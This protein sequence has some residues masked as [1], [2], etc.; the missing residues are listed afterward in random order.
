LCIGET[1]AATAD[2][3]RAL[4]PRSLSAAADPGSPHGI[5]VERDSPAS[6]A[7]A[8]LNSYDAI[9]LANVGAPSAREERLLDRYVASGG[10]VAIFLG[11]RSQ[12]VAYNRFLNLQGESRASSGS[13]DSSPAVQIVNQPAS[14]DFHLD[15]LGYRHPI[16]AP[17][18]G[19]NRAGLLSVR[20]ARYY[21][22]RL[23]GEQI[24]GAPSVTQVLAYSSG[25]PAI[26]L[27]ERGLG[28]IAVVTTDPAIGAGSQPWSTLAVSPSFVPLVRRLFEGLAI[29]RR[30]GD[31]NRLVG[32]PLSP[33][34][35]AS[36]LSL[37]KLSWK[38]PAGHT[39]SAS[40]AALRSGVYTLEH[41][42]APAISIAVNVDAQESDL[43]SLDAGDVI[44][45]DRSRASLS[46]SSAVGFASATPLHP[47]ALALALALV[48][49]ELAVA[50]LFGR[51]WA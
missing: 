49:V 47:Y 12:P 39:S 16:L 11:D 18:A 32:E 29:H 31:L 8:D 43:T 2:I 38:D 34:R 33:P 41:A 1:D 25:D 37:Q 7:T 27:I 26:F 4:N 9:F 28:R 14:G 23:K 22:V 3:A 51:G 42:D 19:R 20:V 21:P 15:P 36:Q 35:A 10:A 17:F 30:G 24:S 6:I 5:N 48:L 46:R 40:P 13:A 44:N 50:W 45:A